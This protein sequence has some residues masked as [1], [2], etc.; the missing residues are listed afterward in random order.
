MIT[1]TMDP[2]DRRCETKL[3]SPFDGGTLIN[4]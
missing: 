4:G 2:P 1:V 3:F